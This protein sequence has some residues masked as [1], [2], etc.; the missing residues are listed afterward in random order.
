MRDKFICKNSIF[1]EISESKSA[2]IEVSF[3]C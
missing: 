3:D 1:K 2:K